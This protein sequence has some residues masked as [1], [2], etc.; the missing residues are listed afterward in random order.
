MAIH[1]RHESAEDAQ[2]IHDLTARAFAPMPFADGDEQMLP[3]RFRSAKALSLSLV[4]ELKGKIVGQLTLTPAIAAN[5]APGWFALGPISVDPSYQKQGIGSTMI[6]AAITWLRAQNAAGCALVG[7]PAYYSR[8]GWLPFPELA[9][10]GEP[11]KYY[12]I[13]PLA[14]AEPTT[15][16]HFHP[17]F[18]GSPT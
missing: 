3:A 12:Q 4:A 11:S 6:A 5:G 7:N 17:L 1:I 15:V 2:A 10:P 18:Y 8:F 13:L 16:I 14:D 9:P